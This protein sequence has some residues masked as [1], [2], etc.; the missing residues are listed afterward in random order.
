MLKQRR[1]DSS[2]GRLIPD[3]IQKVYISVPCRQPQY[4][5]ATR[6][7]PSYETLLNF[8][9]QQHQQYLW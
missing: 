6:Q 1:L 8:L 3:L 7:T 4:H 9:L 5:F 2:A